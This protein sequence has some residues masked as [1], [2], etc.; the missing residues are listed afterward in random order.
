MESRL[1]YTIIGIFI[2]AI[3][4]TLSCNKHVGSA[5]DSNK[6]DTVK[7]GAWYFGGWSFPPDANGHTFHIS[8]TLTSPIQTGNLFGDGGKMLPE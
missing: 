6:A 8:P 2:F 3:S 4:L 1:Q 5:S 7:V